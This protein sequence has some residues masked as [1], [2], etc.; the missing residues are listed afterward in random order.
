M[1][2]VWV[3]KM[4]DDFSSI[5]GIKSFEK[6]SR[7]SEGAL[8][9]EFNCGFWGRK[10]SVPAEKLKTLYTQAFNAHAELVEMIQ[11]M[12][13]SRLK[14]QVGDKQNSLDWFSFW[15]TKGNEPLERRCNK[16]ENLRELL[17]KTIKNKP[18]DNSVLEI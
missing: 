8:Q 16:L 13:S 15:N 9:A 3:T 1:T 4:L 11:E 17:L 14:Q 2:W 5:K 18:K 7:T 12:D 10:V 6:W